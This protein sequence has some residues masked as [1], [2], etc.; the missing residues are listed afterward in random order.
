MK[1]IRPII[2]NTTSDFV[3]RASLELFTNI[4][5]AYIRP[6][7]PRRVSKAPKI[8]FRFISD[9]LILF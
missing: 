1:N 2:P 7:V 8:L 9:V 6:A 4:I 3:S 5:A